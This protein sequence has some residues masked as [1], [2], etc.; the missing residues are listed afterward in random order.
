MR[1]RY[2]TDN[3]W[4]YDGYGEA[5]IVAKDQVQTFADLVKRAADELYYDIEDIPPNAEDYVR[6]GWCKY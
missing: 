5:Y 6:E 1:K 4:D 3:K 2:F